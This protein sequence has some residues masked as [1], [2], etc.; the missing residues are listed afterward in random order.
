VAWHYTLIRTRERGPC[1][2]AFRA[3]HWVGAAVFVGLV[4]DRWLAG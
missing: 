2:A 4:V 1:F 3:N